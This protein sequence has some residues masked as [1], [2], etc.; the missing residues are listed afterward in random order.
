[1]INFLLFAIKEYKDN[2]QKPYNMKKE[3]KNNTVDVHIL[4]GKQD[5]LFP[6]QKTIK[7]ATRFLGSTLKNIEVYEY[8]AHGVETY[9]PAIRYIKKTI[10]KYTV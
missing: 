3:L 1:M 7:N 2:G 10:R 6:Y 4:L 5:S 8:V 9:N